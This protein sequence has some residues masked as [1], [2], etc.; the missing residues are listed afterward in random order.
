M[1]EISELL[2]DIFFVDLIFCHRP[3]QQQLPGPL[4]SA[5][6]GWEPQQPVSP[7]PGILN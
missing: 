6:C 5:W 2:S 1:A 7:T 4:Q 3:L